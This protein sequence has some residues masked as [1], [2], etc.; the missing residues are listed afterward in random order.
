[1]DLRYQGKSLSPIFEPLQLA[2]ATGPP[3]SPAI[4]PS[5]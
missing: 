1:V 5:S 3:Q 2:L 4:E